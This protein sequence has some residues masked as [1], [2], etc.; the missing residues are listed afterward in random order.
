MLGDTTSTLCRLRGRQPVRP[1][2]PVAIDVVGPIYSVEG[3]R[4]RD[5]VESRLRSGSRTI[6]M[7]LSGASDI[8]AAGMGE[9]VRAYNMTVAAAGVLRVTAA[10]GRVRELLSRVGLLELL[11]AS[12]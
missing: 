10:G 12:S 8:D 6:V 1:P 2:E 3:A 7:C 11:T 5:E 9:L 4:L